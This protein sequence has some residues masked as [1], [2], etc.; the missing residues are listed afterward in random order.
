MIAALKG[1]RNCLCLE[2]NPLLF[3]NSKINVVASLSIQ[4]THEKEQNEMENNQEDI[5]N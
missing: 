1:K 3:I 5:T 4:E 2:N